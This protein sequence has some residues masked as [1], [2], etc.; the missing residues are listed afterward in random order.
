MSLCI[1]A[2]PAFA[3]SSFRIVD[4]TMRDGVTLKGNVFTPDTPGRYPAILFITS[5][6]LPS[7]EYFV[8]AQKFADAGY[9]VV[10][11]T[12]RGF[13]TSG[14]F[15]ETAGPK[16][17]ADLS[18]VI[19]WT[20]AQTP[21]DP[22]RI[23]AAGVSYGAGM[24][25]I[26]AAFDSRIRA[27][28]ALSCWTDLPYSLFSHQTRH[29]QSAGLLG[30]SAELTGKPSAEL[31]QA[32]S[33]FFANQNLDSVIAYAQV[34][35]AATYL[36][37]LNANRPAILLGNAYGDS[38]F[39]PN[40]LT[41]F[42]TQ[43]AGPKRLELRPGDHAIPELTGILGLPNDAW[44]STRRWFDQYLRG[45]N[46]GIATE[47][48]VQLQLRGQSTYESFPS[49][50][51]IST[52]TARYNLSEVHWWSNEGD[53]TAGSQ[54]AWNKTLVAGDTVAN[55]GVALLTNGAEAIT[56]EPI[57]AWIPAV[58]RLNGAVWQSDWL[59][60][61][62]RVRGAPHLRLTVT[63]GSSGQTTVI[64]YLYDT[65]WAGTGSLITHVAVT[66]RNAV[67][68]QPY[69]VDVDFPATAY[70]V[71]I[72]HR[73]SL[74]VDTADPLYADKAPAFSSVKLSSSSSSPSYVSLP[75]K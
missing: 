53:L 47:N 43:L 61:P 72:G 30:L 41:G 48:P 68:G 1:A 13:Y 31:Q 57:S 23:G 64:A 10:S 46:T 58:D 33:N 44:T 20:L 29:L 75:L 62:Q 35:S 65:D 32:L 5:W 8:Q 19:D 28:A 69:A 11:Y 21:S 63:P 54:A 37:R 71:P 70:D 50:S 4:L 2:S 73:L 42:F 36:D 24:S 27:V 16:D 12:P 14:G 40:Q 22:A 60:S 26:G 66:L 18:Q 74:V 56:G 3:S 45:V 59:S 25:L 15:I 67:A 38:F 51:A 49:W 52:S 6:A 39:G 34:R 7:V 9:V 55:G 17:I